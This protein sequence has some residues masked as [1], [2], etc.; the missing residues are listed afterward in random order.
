MKKTSK[1]PSRK[2]VFGRWTE[3]ELDEAE[4]VDVVLPRGLEALDEQR[5]VVLEGQHVVS[6]I[7]SL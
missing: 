2:R 3:A 1:K 7:N 4:L 6:A 5:V